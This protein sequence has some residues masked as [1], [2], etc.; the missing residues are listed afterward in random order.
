MRHLFYSWCVINPALCWAH[1]QA[2]RCQGR[3]E[4]QRHGGPT[5]LGLIFLS[6]CQLGSL[7]LGIWQPSSLVLVGTP[8][9]PLQ[10]PW[11]LCEGAE[12]VPFTDGS[13]TWGE[14]GCC[15]PSTSPTIDGHKLPHRSSSV[16]SGGQSRASEMPWSLFPTCSS[17]FLS[18]P[19]SR[20]LLLGF[21]H[22][23][24]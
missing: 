23:E 13:L 17:L 4:Q 22:P 7:W 18:C 6:C 3:R 9:L 11:P 14:P 1:P 16:I 19:P 8:W 10:R 12:S 5:R 24:S 20:F 21:S 2:S 15:G